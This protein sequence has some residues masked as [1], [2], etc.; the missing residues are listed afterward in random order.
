MEF[1]HSEAARALRLGITTV[2]NYSIGK[3][4]DTE[5]EVEVPYSVLLA[6]AAVEKGLLPIN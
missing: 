1:T 3:R 6:C 5:H 2:S 4:C